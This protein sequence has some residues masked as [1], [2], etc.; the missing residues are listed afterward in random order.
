MYPVMHISLSIL[1]ILH[2]NT[3]N[4]NIG[5]Q[6]V[7]LFLPRDAMHGAVLHVVIVNLSICLC[8]TRGLCPRG[9]T[10]G[11]DFFIIRQLH[12]S[13]FLVQ[14]FVSIFQRHDLQ[15]KGQIRVR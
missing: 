7:D 13:S 2:V 3:N 14:N 1:Y 8:H 11:H 15:I 9:S 12:D 10:Y 5:E 6:H 4:E